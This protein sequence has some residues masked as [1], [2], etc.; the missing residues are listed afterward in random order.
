MRSRL[1]STVVL[2]FL[3][4]LFVAEDSAAQRRKR[5]EKRRQPAEEEQVD[6][7]IAESEE[8]TIESLGLFVYPAEDQSAG[9]Q[10]VD[11]QECLEWAQEEVGEVPAGDGETEVASSGDSDPE[12]GRGAG[13]RPG[14]RGAAKGAA[15]GAVVDE[16][17][18]PD[19]D[20]I[21][22]GNIDRGDTDRGNIDQGDIGDGDSRDQA[23]HNLEKAADDDP[24]AAEIG[25]VTGAVAGRSRARRERSAEAEQSEAVES[26]ASQVDEPAVE[27][28]RK[29]VKVCL[30]GRGYSVE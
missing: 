10:E 23:R 9:Q 25:A 21:D 4:V 7:S 29:A 27:D 19:F 3:V 28:L 6:E 20:D 12:K 22:R 16:V 18:E 1:L 30:E 2:G 14:L 15:V 5:A 8:P 13:G 24:S 26:Q 17:N 11:E